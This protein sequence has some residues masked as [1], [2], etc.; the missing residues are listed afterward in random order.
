MQY[1]VAQ[2]YYSD[3]SIQL[4]IEW[5]INRLHCSHHSLYSYAVTQLCSFSYLRRDVVWIPDCR[6]LGGHAGTQSTGPGEEGETHDA[7]K[8]GALAHTTGKRRQSQRGQSQQQR[9]SQQRQSQQQRNIPKQQQHYS[10]T[11]PSRP[12]Q[13]AGGAYCL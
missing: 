6:Q 8:C 10:P 11:S 3:H 4:L 2:L 1:A 13:C 7:L 5:A 9:Q 12:P